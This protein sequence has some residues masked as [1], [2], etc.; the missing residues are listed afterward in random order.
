MEVYLS[1]RKNNTLLS[2][3]NDDYRRR[4]KKKQEYKISKLWE[5]PWGCKT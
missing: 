3:K 1:Q 5:D 4:E 2:L